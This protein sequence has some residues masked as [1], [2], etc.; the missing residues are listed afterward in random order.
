MDGE[1]GLATGRAATRPPAPP[2]E[3]GWAL[4]LPWCLP[5][6]AALCQAFTLQEDMGHWTLPS[7]WY[8]PVWRWCSERWATPCLLLPEPRTGAEGDRGLCKVAPYSRSKS[9]PFYP[10]KGWAW[11]A[12]PGWTATQWRGTYPPHPPEGS[13]T[14]PGRGRQVARGMSFYIHFE[15]LVKI[16]DQDNIFTHSFYKARVYIFQ[17]Y[18]N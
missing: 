16:T 13:W 3:D 7:A 6:G 5:V 12:I 2:R 8:L 4:S 10:G 18:G 17:F 11:P 9:R 14:P 15:T 1:A